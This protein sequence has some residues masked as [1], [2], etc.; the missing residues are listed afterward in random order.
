MKNIKVEDDIWEKL[1]KLKLKRKKR[2]I[3][4]VI[5]ELLKNG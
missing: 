1:S 2:R 5:E 3:N 4:D